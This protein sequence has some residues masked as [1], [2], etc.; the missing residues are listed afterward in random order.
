MKKVFPENLHDYFL[1]GCYLR[2]WSCCF[3]GKVTIQLKVKRIGES[4]VASVNEVS[5]AFFVKHC[6]FAASASGAPSV[7]C[8]SGSE[9]F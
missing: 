1:R 4:T 8:E 2:E 5:R 9:F 7:A 6:G 3:Q